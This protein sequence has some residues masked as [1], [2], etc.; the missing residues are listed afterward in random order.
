MHSN[1]GEFEEFQ[2]FFFAMKIRKNRLKNISQKNYLNFVVTNNLTN[3]E[4][5]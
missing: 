1:R 2:R 5:E 4:L 3:R